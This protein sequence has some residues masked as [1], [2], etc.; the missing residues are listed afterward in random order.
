MQFSL[1][2]CFSS[3]THLM[4]AIRQKALFVFVC[5]CCYC[6]VMTMLL[7]C[8]DGSLLVDISKQLRGV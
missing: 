8:Y 7:F 1:I 4:M 6:F 5:F 2:F 3:T